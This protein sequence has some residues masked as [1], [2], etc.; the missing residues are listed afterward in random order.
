[1]HGIWVRPIA[2]SMVRTTGTIRFRVRPSINS[3]GKT[4]SGCSCR[5][6]WRAP[7]RLPSSPVSGMI[8]QPDQRHLESSPHPVVSTG[9]GAHLSSLG[10]GGYRPPTLF[11][12]HRD[13]RVTTNIPTGLPFPLPSSSLQPYPV[14]GSTGLAPER[15]ISYEAGYQGWYWKHAYAS[16]G[17]IL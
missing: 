11:E 5:D 17:S 13:Q 2:S 4:G 9:R 6:E 3:A 15:I 16:G 8:S 14:T 1:M 7:P 12:S 10:I